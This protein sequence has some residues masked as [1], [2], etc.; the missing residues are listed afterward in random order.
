MVNFFE[1]FG[2]ASK[3]NKEQ[4]EEEKAG[5]KLRREGI[6]FE[7]NSNKA[8]EG[9]VV[10]SFGFETKR[11]ILKKITDAGLSE[12]GLIWCKRFGKDGKISY[13]TLDFRELNNS[14]VSVKKPE[15]DISRGEISDKSF[16]A[17]I[18]KGIEIG[19]ALISP[20]GSIR[21]II[22]IDVDKRADSD[23]ALFMSKV[24]G[25]FE[26]IGLDRLAVNKNKFLAILTAEQ[27]EEVKE[28]A[29]ALVNNFSFTDEA[30][31]KRKIKE[32]EGK[33]LRDSIM[34][35]TRKSMPD[36]YKKLAERYQN[37]Q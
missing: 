17:E 13:D 9:M 5:A 11:L 32:N 18:L 4:E 15:P 25:G 21:E 26:V 16:A 36:V 3:K 34:N 19:G 2:F 22:D 1:I 20:S 23:G 24:G 7:L 10:M 27:M 14:T 28:D 12:G 35:F 37:R 6:R 30:D 29:E 31:R 33:K 8:E